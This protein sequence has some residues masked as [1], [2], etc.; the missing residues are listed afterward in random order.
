MAIKSFLVPENQCRTQMINENKPIRWGDSTSSPGTR[1]SVRW[2]WKYING[3]QTPHLVPENQCRTQTINENK[4]MLY[5]KRLRA[6]QS[7]GA[8]RHRN[9]T[10]RQTDGH[11]NMSMA[12]SSTVC[13]KTN[14]ERKRWTR[15]NWCYI[16]KDRGPISQVERLGIAIAH[17]IK[18]RWPWKYVNGHKIFQCARNKRRTQ[19]T[20][21][22]NIRNTKNKNPQVA[23]K[24]NRRR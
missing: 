7:S 21:E 16:R 9:W 1:Q 10:Y 22:D 6:N 12:M 17:T 24:S 4:L 14:V 5:T 3:Y 2:P 15:T 20:G 11:G 13:T 23:V 19:A 18:I 8:T